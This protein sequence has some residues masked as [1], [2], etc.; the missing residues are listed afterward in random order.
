MDIPVNR[1]NVSLSKLRKD[2]NDLV[3]E[4]HTISAVSDQPLMHTTWMKWK[5]NSYCKVSGSSAKCFR[6]KTPARLLF[7]THKLT[8]ESWLNDDI[9]DIA[10]S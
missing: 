10:L 1:C 2:C 6:C 9:E 5:D 3:I 4:V 8:P 7:K